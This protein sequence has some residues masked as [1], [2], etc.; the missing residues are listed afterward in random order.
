[1]HD[2]TCQNKGIRLRITKA[3]AEKEKET[4]N[5]TKITLSNIKKQTGKEID[6]VLALELQE[7]EA[8]TA[9]ANGKKGTAIEISYQF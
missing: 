9:V 3:D 5:G 1:M 8:G 4:S 6:V 2:V 7:E